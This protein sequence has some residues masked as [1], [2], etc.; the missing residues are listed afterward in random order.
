MIKP[1]IRHPI[2]T[3]MLD[4]LSMFLIL[5]LIRSY[6]DP[7]VGRDVVFLFLCGVYSI[8]DTLLLQQTAYKLGFT[9][10]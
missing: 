10:E 2:I 3:M 4:Y 6:L 5:T 9:Q 7:S 1:M 8:A